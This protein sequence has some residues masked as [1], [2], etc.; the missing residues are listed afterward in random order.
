MTNT[1]IIT[2]LV[3]IDS[4]FRGVMRKE[5]APIWIDALA[6]YEESE[7]N[8]AIDRYIQT[9]PFPPKP[10][11]IIR[12]LPERKSTYI[13]NGYRKDNLEEIITED[14]EVKRFR[15]YKCIDCSDTG[16]ITWRNSND[17]LVGK[18]CRC[19][20]GKMRYPKSYSEYYESEAYAQR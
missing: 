16:L 12:L 8:K 7:V 13:S 15:V 1:E 3:K 2:A 5:S 19:E 4:V 17:C 11:D 10:A 18:P 20:L 14:G 9:K 6:P